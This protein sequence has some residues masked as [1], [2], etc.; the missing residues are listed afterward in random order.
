[1]SHTTRVPY[2]TDVTVLGAVRR[3]VAISILAPTHRTS[4]ENQADPIMVKNLVTA[5]RAEAE[6]QHGKRDS[7]AALDALD[8]LVDDIDWRHT[9]EGLALYVADD[10]THLFHLPHSPA[11]SSVVSDN[12]AIRELSRAVAGAQRHWVLVLSELD[13]RLLL[14]NGTVLTEIQRTFPLRHEGPG[15]GSPL[16]RGRGLNPSAQRDEHHRRFFRTVHEAFTAEYEA[17]PLPLFVTGVDRYLAFWSEVS[18]HPAVA[19][20]I[21]GSFDALTAHEIATRIDPTVQEFYAARRLDVLDQVHAAL[22]D[23]RFAGG[24]QE[25]TT[26]AEQGRV[27]TLLVPDTGY[28]TETVDILIEN[29]LTLGG[30]VR[31]LEPEALTDHGGIAAI[32]R[33]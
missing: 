29:V 20:T 17:E 24:I 12:F 3:P 2:R 14:G 8:A 27:H 25:V 21:N 32:L 31:F 1:M 18:P 26:L 13:T 4:P 22:S 10:Q 9:T 28:D 6:A 19:G 33:Y 11:P 30:D 5:A 16:T 23:N 15:G 7:A